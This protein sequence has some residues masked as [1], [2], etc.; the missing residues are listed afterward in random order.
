MSEIE[1]QD[2]VDG[3]QATA[4]VAFHMTDLSCIYPITPSSGMGELCD[5][6]A[7]QHK[8][9]CFDEVP[10]VRELQ[11]EGG[12]AGAVHG[13]LASGAL[14]TTFTASQGL[15]LMIPNMYKIAGELLPCVFH[16]AARA[17]A[18]QALSIFGDHSDV[19]AV[20]QTGF[21]LLSSHSVQE[22]HDMAIISHMATLDTSVP[23]VH[24]F[25]GFRVSHEI[26]RI[27]MATPSAMKQ[28]IDMSSVEKHRS[29]AL[30]PLHPHQQGTSQ[31]PDIY[32]QLVEA[33]N[34]YHASVPEAVE[35]A[36]EKFG[37]ITGRKYAPFKYIGANDAELVM[38]IMGAGGPVAEEA[39]TYLVGKGEKVG[40]LKVHLYRPWSAEHFLKVLPK[41]CTHIAVLDRCKEPGSLGEPLCLDVAA[42]LQRESSN[43][44]VVG[45]RYGLGSKDF[46][47]SMVQSIFQNLRL[48]NPKRGFT[49]GIND[50]VSHT[51]LP[52]LPD[53]DTAPAGTLECLFYG[54]ASDGTVGANK[55]A[56]K[57]IG[58]HTHKFIQGY[59]EYDA[60]KAG[61]V[62]VSHLRVS[63]R[64]ITSQYLVRFADYVAC[65]NPRYVHQ[66]DMLKNIKRGGTFVLNCDWT[67]DEL[68]EKLPASV[69]KR[70][71][72]Q[73]V[74]LFLVNAAGIAKNANLGK[75]VNTALMT[76]F[77][78]KTNIMNFEKAV[79]LINESVRKAYQAKGED[80][81]KRNLACIRGAIGAASEVHYDRLAWC[82]LQPKKRHLPHL[83]GA[84]AFVKDIMMPVLAQEGNS[85]PV[86]AFEAGGRMPSGTTRYEKRS[87]AVQIP[88]WDAETCIQCNQCAIV[89][90]HAAIRPFLLTEEDHEAIDDLTVL[91]AKGIPNMKYRIQVSP[92]DCTGCTLCDQACP[93]NC[94]SMT[95]IEEVKDIESPNWNYLESLP[96]RMDIIEK[97]TV[98]GSQ[99]Q[100]PLLEFSGACEGCG[101]TPYVKL[102]TQ[103]F[104]TRMVIANA[105]GCSSIWGGSATSNPYTTNKAGRGPAWAN[106]LF[107]DNAEFG[108]GMRLANR[109]R[110]QA[111]RNRV[112][113]VL[114]D[115]A[116]PASKPLRSLL[117]K[118]Q[119]LCDTDADASGRIADRILPLL[120][121]EYHKHPELEQVYH[122]RDMLHT[123]SQWIIGG[124]GWAYDIGFG[125]LDHVLASGENVN[126]LVMDTE[127][128]SNTG[129]QTSKATPLG[130]AMRFSLGGKDAG[131]KDLGK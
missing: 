127:S 95:D 124:D 110:R 62:T 70:I 69:R 119:D 58:K 22:A 86:S 92:M 49:V 94:L 14:A 83:E 47:P 121:T 37:R 25:D 31:A 109:S 114:N 44:K 4:H 78:E 48:P 79:G 80:V 120:E 60:K 125:G 56:I 108:L 2:C 55:N 61:G 53:L 9:N 107:E 96:D 76:V 35:K 87:I 91:D 115:V 99:F 126:V 129:G 90:P 29:R 98:R 59:F 89:C 111:L 102:L 84:P 100:T 81:I 18:G 57:I 118:W 63:E 42:T 41:T 33:S 122:Q 123:V 103:L 8:R 104:G 117:K 21:A 11:S 12:A 113:K 85:L 66:I 39:V 34:N 50:D 20:R 68:D 101:E 71:A 38:V 67:Q 46:T 26:Q 75:R 32:F 7:S 65:H 106:S 6:W 74:R 88:I 1:F 54:Y 15:L 43:I 82:Q 3:G 72:E 51:S 131:K 13:A 128:Y 64:P 27:K 112:H 77:F 19:M 17:I 28:F 116:I 5:A 36:M 10:T 40:V 93:V 30:S 24:F 16:V 73:D 52:I 45:G 97:N 105:T 23:F 130:A